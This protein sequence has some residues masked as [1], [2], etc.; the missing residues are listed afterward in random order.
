MGELQAEKI[1]EIKNKNAKRFNAATKKLLIKFSPFTDVL[2]VN[3]RKSNHTNQN[4]IAPRQPDFHRQ[5]HGRLHTSPVH[6]ARIS[7]R[8]A[9]AP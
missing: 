5:K 2:C 9:E 8:R 7:R 1:K 4:N 6:A 3:H